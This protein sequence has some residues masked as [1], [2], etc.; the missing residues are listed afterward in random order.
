MQDRGGAEPAPPRYFAPVPDHPPS[1]GDP[2]G[3]AP[4]ARRPPRVPGACR[5]ARRGDGGRHPSRPRIGAEPPAPAH[6]HAAGAGAVRARRGDRRGAAGRDG[7]GP[8]D[9]AADHRAVSG[10]D[11]G[12]GPRR[13]SRSMSI[14]ETNPD[15]RRPRRRA[16]SRAR[17]QRA[18]RGPLHG[19]PVLLKDNIDTADRMTTTAGSLAL[20]GSIPPRD[21]HVAERLRAAGAVLLAKANMSE[22]ANIRSSRSSSGWSA[23]G[24]AVP[25]SVRARPEPLRVELGLGRGRLGQLRGRSPS[26]PRPTDRSSVPRPPTGWSASSRR[27]GW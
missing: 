24:R 9:G 4:R 17:G 8:T 27:S 18:P 5:R 25:Q 15:A 16:R 11:R 10:A 19:V 3:R 1:A 26:G 2:D 13:A 23:R 22:W 6:R 20:E 7:P 21:A 14:I 12:D